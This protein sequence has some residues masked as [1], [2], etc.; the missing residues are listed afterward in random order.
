M[1]I[2]SPWHRKAEPAPAPRTVVGLW[3]CCGSHTEIRTDQLVDAQ[4]ERET[5]EARHRGCLPVVPDVGGQA[6]SGPRGYG[7]R[8]TM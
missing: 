3:C 7:T 2:L 4:A 1:S 6:M 8:G 5:W